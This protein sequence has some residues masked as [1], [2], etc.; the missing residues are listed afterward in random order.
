MKVVLSVL[1]ILVVSIVVAAVAVYCSVVIC[2][3]QADAVAD[4]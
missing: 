3:S 2:M 1:C 4:E